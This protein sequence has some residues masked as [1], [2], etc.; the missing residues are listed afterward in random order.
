MSP[1]QDT[2]EPLSWVPTGVPRVYHPTMRILEMLLKWLS[3]ARCPYSEK[4]MCV[5]CAMG[6]V[7]AIMGVAVVVVALVVLF[8]PQ[9]W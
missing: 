6:S 4:P 8:A 7:F 2:V 1:S 3:P 9:V 5:G